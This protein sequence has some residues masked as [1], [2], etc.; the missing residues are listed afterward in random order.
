MSYNPILRSLK[1]TL[2]FTHFIPN[3]TISVSD[4]ILF[5][6]ITVNTL[7]WNFEMEF[8]LIFFLFS[9]SIPAILAEDIVHGTIIVDG[10]TTVS[11]TDDNFICAT[12]DWWPHD[13]CDYNQCP[14]HYTSVINL[15][16]L[17]KNNPLHRRLIYFS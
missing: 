6:R 5:P 17:N 11:E 16:R 9:A 13:K 15:V 4:R 12:I 3:A 7:R 14:W 1:Y 10:S 2:K 8:W